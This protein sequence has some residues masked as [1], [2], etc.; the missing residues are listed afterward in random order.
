MPVYNGEACL[1]ESLESILGQTLDDFELVVVDDGS[2]DSTWSILRQYAGRD[3]RVI[4]DRHER[5]LGIVAALN[6]GLSL[7][8]G[9]YIARQDADDVS[10]PVRLS[11][12][13][14]FLESHRE[15]GL[16][17]SFYYRLFANGERV[18]RRPP[19]EDTLIRWRLLFGNVWCHASIMLRRSTL[20]ELD[21]PRYRD[22]PHAEDYD[23]WLVNSNDFC[24]LDHMYSRLLAD[25]HCRT[26]LP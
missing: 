4:L 1:R 24:L 15:V 19:E 25:V 23:L 8:R 20:L 21:E 22:F 6:R 11:A 14:E 2:T 9:R 3:G 7:A 26:P 18:L 5:N 16:L 10:L 17:G 13:T 12:Q